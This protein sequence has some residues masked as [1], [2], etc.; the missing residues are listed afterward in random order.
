MAPSTA[1]VPELHHIPIRRLYSFDPPGAIDLKLEAELP[2]TGF[3][4]EDLYGRIVNSQPQR[5]RYGI[6]FTS[7]GPQTA[8][9]VRTLVQRLMQGSV[10]CG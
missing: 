4:T 2:F 3:R 8:R 10:A 7:L 1:Q 5:G 9:E 6:E